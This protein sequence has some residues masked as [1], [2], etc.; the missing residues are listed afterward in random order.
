[1]PRR[2]QCRFGDRFH[3]DFQHTVKANLV[4]EEQ[5]NCVTPTTILESQPDG[6]PGQREV[7]IALNGGADGT[8]S[9]VDFVGRFEYYGG[10]LSF[11]FY[12]VQ[13]V[14]LT[15]GGCVASS[16]SRIAAGPW[17]CCER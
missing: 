11:I 2:A 12:H 13:I 9:D 4:S 15:P 3:A 10:P 6:F 5:I 16:A 17:S 1:M 14:A 8:P 7:R